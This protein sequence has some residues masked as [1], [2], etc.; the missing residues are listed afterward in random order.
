M[1]TVDEDIGD[2]VTFLSTDLNE[3]LDHIIADMQANPSRRVVV[4]LSLGLPLLGSTQAKIL[5][6]KALG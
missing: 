5:T 2:G 3:A 1:V 6:I 4:N